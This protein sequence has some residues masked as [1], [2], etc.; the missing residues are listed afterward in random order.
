M[1]AYA[2]LAPLRISSVL[3]WVP[4]D[5]DHPT[6]TKMRIS[7]PENVP[8]TPCDRSF[9]LISG[10]IIVLEFVGLLLVFQALRAIW[11]SLNG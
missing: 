2:V 9:V 5:P 1:P 7:L 4:W 10:G 11:G 3:E 8:G 6:W